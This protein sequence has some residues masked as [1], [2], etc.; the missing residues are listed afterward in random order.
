MAGDERPTSDGGGDEGLQ[1]GLPGQAVLDWETPASICTE[2]AYLPAVAG[3]SCKVPNNPAGSR[4]ERRLLRARTGRAVASGTVCLSAQGLCWVPLCSTMSAA[5]SSVVVADGAGMPWGWLVCN[6]DQ[7]GGR[8][9]GLKQGEKSKL[10]TGMLLMQGRMM[11]KRQMS[12]TGAEAPLHNRMSPTSSNTGTAPP[13]QLRKGPWTGQSERPGV[14]PMWT[15]AA[16]LGTLQPCA[17]LQGQGGRQLPGDTALRMHSGRRWMQQGV[18][19]VP[20]MA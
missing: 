7:V 20:G 9:R 11:V 3:L 15:G 17:A 18:G 2:W 4:Q 6:T 10:R 12:Q 5:Y 8:Q 19:E 13:L 16:L 1:G 14:P